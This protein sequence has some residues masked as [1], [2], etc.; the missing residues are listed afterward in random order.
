MQQQSC[1]RF[2]GFSVDI[3]KAVAALKSKSWGISEDVGLRK[4]FYYTNTIAILFRE[5][6]DFYYD[7]YEDYNRELHS[8]TFINRKT[9]EIID[10]KDVDDIT[11][12]ECLR[13]VDLMISISSNTI[14]DYELAMSTTEM[15]QAVLKSIIQILKL[16]NISFLKDNIKIEGYYGNYIINI[17]TGL[18][19]MEGKGKLLV[20]TIY[21]SN[22]ALLLDFVDEDPMTADIISKAIVFS[23]D[24]DIKASSILIQIK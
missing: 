22:K 13:D 14:Y 8:I 21:S 4:V 23:N 19:Y 16:N 24:K 12:S 18:V 9:E 2:R 5:F 10:L 1:I 7:D 17:R 20:D 15:R 11:Y 3:K 6:D